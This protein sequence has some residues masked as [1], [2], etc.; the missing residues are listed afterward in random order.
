[1]ISIRNLRHGILDI[2]TLDIAPGVTSLIGPN[3]SGKT[4]LLKALTGLTL[5]DSG[6]IF[7]DGQPPRNTSAGWVNEFPDRNILFETV[8]DEIASSLRFHRVPCDEIDR[9]ITAMV[10]FM[11]IAHLHHRRVNGLSGG[12]KILVAL[13]AAIIMNPMMLVLDEYD[14][15]LDDNRAHEVEEI[16]KKTGIPYIFR[17]TQQMDTAERSTSIIYLENGKVVHQGAPREVFSSLAGTAFYPLSRR[18]GL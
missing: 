10:D 9:R 18:C 2:E 4:T 1:M 8:E 3:G 12:E 11:K 15:H 16:L 13:A 5:P 7:V 6:T 17:C 14:S